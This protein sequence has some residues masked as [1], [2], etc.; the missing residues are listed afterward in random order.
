MITRV[1]AHPLLTAG[2][3]EKVRTRIHGLDGS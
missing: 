2:P 3:Y 1:E